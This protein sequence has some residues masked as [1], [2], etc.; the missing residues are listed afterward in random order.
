MLIKQY[1]HRLPSDYDMSTIR[2]RG[3]T[4]GLLWDHAEGLAFKAFALRERGQHGAHHNA[5]TSIYL[6]L[7]E[8]EAAKFVI[9]P[10]FRSV[11]D[12][13]GRPPIQTWLPIALRTGQSSTALSIYREDIPIDEGADLDALRAA[14]TERVAQVAARD[15][16]VLALAGVDVFD[17]QLTRFTLS[18]APLRAI[19]GVAAYEIVYLAAPGLQRLRERRSIEIEHVEQ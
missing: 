10:R 1:E 5:Y 3:R 12:S 17:W 11:I 15:D 6:W 4:R 2:E 13:F 7:N 14:E 16:T 9:G 8:D 19:E 18:S